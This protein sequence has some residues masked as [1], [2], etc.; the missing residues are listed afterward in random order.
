MADRKLQ[1]EIEAVDNITPVAERA[2]AKQEEL[3]GAILDTS[4]LA[5]G[6][7]ATLPSRAEIGK[8]RQLELKQ[9]VEETNARIAEQRMKFIDNAV[10]LSALREGITGTQTALLQ[11]GLIEEKNA[12]KFLKMAAAVSLF[13]SAA[14][15]IQGIIRLVQLLRDAEIALAAVQTYRK[16]LANPALLAVAGG[17]MVAAAGVG[18][19]YYGKSKG[20]DQAEAQS[21]TVNNTTN[22]QFV[23]QG[24]QSGQ[25]QRGVQQEIIQFVGE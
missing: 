25:D 8:Q 17:A 18:G 5:D 3:K 24:G 20:K 23:F 2:K 10:A 22:N 4:A 14:Q 16:I 15:T 7:H 9:T 21:R 19:Y 11:L 13:V 6:Q 12:E 1:Y